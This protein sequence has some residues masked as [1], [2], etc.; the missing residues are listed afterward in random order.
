MDVSELLVETYDRLPD[1]VRGAVEGLTPQQLSWAPAVGA[2]SI[3][4]LVWH[5][6][7][8]QDD[9]IADILG[10]DQIWVSGDW[11]RRFALDP[12][13]AN[14][15][16]GHSAEDIATVQPES[17]AALID[18]YE[19]VHARTRDLLRGLTANEL[20]RI[21]DESWQPPVTLG[22]R[23]VSIVNDDAQHVGQ[24]A[25]LRGLQSAG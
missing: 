9:H 18:Y 17:D 22:V 10:Q 11:A 25:Y 23:L 21:V 4:W 8:I 15:G 6:T 3:G 20:D 5:L 12:D 19:A 2:N 24:A 14:T 16:F 1:L 7:R 13:P